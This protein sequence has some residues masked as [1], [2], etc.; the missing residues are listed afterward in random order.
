MNCRRLN[1]YMCS[2]VVLYCC[3]LTLQGTWFNGD[4]VSSYNFFFLRLTQAHTYKTYVC[5]RSIER[6]KEG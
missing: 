1:M 4:A 6:K 5:Q 3:G 2:L